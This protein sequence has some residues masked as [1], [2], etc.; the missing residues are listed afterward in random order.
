MKISRLKANEP[1]PL[2]E[3]NDFQKEH[4]NLFGLHSSSIHTRKEALPLKKDDLLAQDFKFL[5]NLPITFKAK[6]TLREFK[7]ER[8]Q[9][10]SFNRLVA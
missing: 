5:K 4:V 10:N 6:K 7:E 2:A 9:K 8:V 3:M 1:V